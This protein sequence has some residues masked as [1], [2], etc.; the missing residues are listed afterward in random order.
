[1]YKFWTKVFLLFAFTSI[2]MASHLYSEATSLSDIELKK[3]IELQTR[4]LEKG[5]NWSESELTRQAQEIVTR[6]EAFLLDNPDDINALLL[7]GKF[8]RK[9]GLH[10]NAISIFL[11]ADQINPN[12][13]VIKQELGNFL[14]EKGKPMEAFPFFLLTTRLEPAKAVYHYNLGNFI[15]IFHDNLVGIENSEKLGAL[16]HQSFKEAAILDPANF[17]YHLRYAQS[18]FDF[19]NE[20]HEEAISAW[21]TLLKEFGNRSQIEV[22]YIKMN[23]AKIFLKMGQNQEVY[24]ILDSVRSESIQNEKRKLLNQTEKKTNEKSKK[25]SMIDRSLHDIK[26]QQ[27]NSYSFPIDSN[28]KRIKQITSKLR[29]ESMLKDLRYDVTRAHILANGDL[30]L[31]LTYKSIGSVNFE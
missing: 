23:I 10:E 6:Y 21:N 1:M 22:D 15:F 25:N 14:V 4:V 26:Y 3:I 13:A 5:K 28:L 27:V 29:Q 20:F 12:I 24:D 31:E 7:F 8:L 17:D 16:M 30:S 9:T 11:K 18:F 19:S 2:R